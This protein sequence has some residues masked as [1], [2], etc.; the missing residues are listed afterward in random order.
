MNTGNFSTNMAPTSP[1]DSGLP[2]REG[3]GGV[4]KSNYLTL[5]HL[6]FSFDDDAGIQFDDILYKDGLYVSW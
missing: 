3:D 6:S 2:Y 4:N 1:V 5:F